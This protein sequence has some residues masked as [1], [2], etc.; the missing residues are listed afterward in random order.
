MEAP[1]AGPRQAGD[2]RERPISRQVRQLVA[3]AFPA[4]HRDTRDRCD[5]VDRYLCGLDGLVARGHVLRVS[6]GDWL[7]LRP[8]LEVELPMVAGAVGRP[9]ALLDVGCGEGWQACFIAGLHP[10]TIVVGLDESE[11]AVAQA[12]ILAAHLHREVRFIEGKAETISALFPGQ[13]FQVVLESGVLP[14]CRRRERP[15]S[16]RARD[17]AEALALLRGIREAVDSA[18]GR[19]L[20]LEGGRSLQPLR[21]HA[22]L[23]VRAKLDIDW[24]ASDF[25]WGMNARGAFLWWLLVSRLRQAP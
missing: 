17:T 11:E 18:G 19:F 22:G 9:S 15:P 16:E 2:H 10:G 7:L 8:V 1:A 12:W 6:P 23:L 25:G 13:T 5:E 21:Y 4:C 14:V 3:T 24:E 20:W